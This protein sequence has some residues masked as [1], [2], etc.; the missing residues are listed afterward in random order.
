[1]INL[2][3]RKRWVKIRVNVLFQHQFKVLRSTAFAQFKVWKS[4]YFYLASKS[5]TGIPYLISTSHIIITELVLV[6][7][8]AFTL[9]SWISALHCHVIKPDLFPRGK[10]I[11]Y[12]CLLKLHTKHYSANIS[13]IVLWGCY[14]KNITF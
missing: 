13:G 6:E 3:V 7:W 12:K 9:N 5:P 11:F 8:I 14:S 2:R 10:Q 4:I 1:M